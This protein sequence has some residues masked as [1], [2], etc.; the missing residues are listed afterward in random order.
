[1]RRVPASTAL[2]P[3]ASDLWLPLSRGFEG[4]WTGVLPLL[5][6]LL[7]D[8]DDGETGPQSRV[9]L[10]VGRTFADQVRCG[11]G[12]AHPRTLVPSLLRWCAFI[13]PVYRQPAGV[14]QQCA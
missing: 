14:W 4:P 5:A 12:M 13:T 10:T 9:T 6:G 2:L 7:F 1:M 3:L 11:G 8:T